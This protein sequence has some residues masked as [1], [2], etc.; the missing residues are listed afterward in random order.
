MPCCW[1]RAARPHSHQLALPGVQWI[2][3]RALHTRHF[4]ATSSAPLLVPRSCPFRP[5]SP[6]PTRSPFFHQ[7]TASFASKAAGGN[8]DEKPTR[9][10]KKKKGETAGEEADATSDSTAPATS[11]PVP[12][13]VDGS[14]PVRATTATLS[15]EGME[16]LSHVL[17]SSPS[18][19][20]TSYPTPPPR[21]SPASITPAPRTRLPLTQTPPSSLR[22][23]L[24]PGSDVIDPSISVLVRRSTVD[25]LVMEQIIDTRT[26][27]VAS[28]PEL[29][30]LI[31]RERDEERA[32]RAS[33]RLSLRSRQSS[34]DETSRFAGE[35]EEYV[36]AIEE[37]NE[38]EQ[39]IAENP[40]SMRRQHAID[41]KQI[42]LDVRER[43]MEL[44]EADDREKDQQTAASEEQRTANAERL[45]RLDAH[46]ADSDE[47]FDEYDPVRRLQEEEAQEALEDKVA[48]FWCA[49]HSSGLHKLHSYDSG[50]LS[51]AALGLTLLSIIPPCALIFLKPRKDMVLSVFATTAWGFFLCSYQVHEKNVLLPL[52]PMTLLLGTQDGMKAATRSWVGY[53][54]TVACWTMFPLLSRDEL[55]IPYLVLTL[56]W[57]YL[58]ALPPFS[59][60]AYSMTRTEGGLHG[61]SK[62]LHL[63]TYAA[64]LVWHVVEAT[65]PPPEAKPDLWVVANVCL[66][67]A[68]FAACYLW[69][70]WRTVELSGL[71]SAQPRPS[72]SAK[73][74]Q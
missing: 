22:I 69:C 16:R 27:L 39:L 41:L 1:H 48:N 9:S 20:P 42:R 17:S 52:L 30:L 6:T 56:L 71:L 23:P 51:K 37:Y 49:I 46:E 74:T 73:K 26:K 33:R 11:A 70:L 12:A 40:E 61:T 15:R 67:A 53:A 25:D 36:Y 14:V 7:P 59:L 64:M 62:L 60:V 68:A 35:E 45:R 66:G 54:N 44:E 50:L 32:V 19:A 55:R 65:S 13:S 24:T 43:M 21:S 28:K 63:G 4:S 2:P 72:E 29:S 5:T 31:K 18:S 47:A 10:K 34:S 3:H 58:M 57:A 8:K 38:N